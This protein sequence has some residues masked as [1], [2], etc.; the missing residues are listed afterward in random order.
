MRR[1][2]SEDFFGFVSASL[3]NQAV[4]F[5]KISRSVFSC[6]FSRRSFTSSSRSALLSTSF[7]LPSFASACATQLR[8]VCSEGSNSLASLAWTAAGSHQIYDLLAKLRRVR[9]SCFRHFWTP[10]HP[11]D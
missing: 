10:S 1:Y 11:K 6:L 3:A 4:A 9:H 5:A 2:E 7:R 8:I